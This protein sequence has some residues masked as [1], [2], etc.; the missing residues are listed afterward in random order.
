MD[1]TE[2]TRLID[3]APSA[4]G[5]LHEIKYDGYRAWFIEGFDAPDIKDAGELLRNLNA[6]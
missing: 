5:W 2:L 1:Q 6:R 4:D 3:E